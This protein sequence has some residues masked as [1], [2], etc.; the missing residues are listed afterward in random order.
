[1]YLDLFCHVFVL[2]VCPVFSMSFSFSPFPLLSFGLIFSPFHSFSLYWFGSYITYLYSFSGYSNNFSMQTWTY[3]S[4]INIFIISSKNIS[5]LEHSNTVTSYKVCAL[6]MYLSFLL[7]PQD[8]IITITILI[9][10]F[11]YLTIEVLLLFLFCKVCIFTYL[12]T[13]VIAP[14]FWLNLSSSTWIALPLPAVNNWPFSLVKVCWWQTQLCV[15]LKCL[16]FI[17]ILERLLLSIEFCFLSAYWQ[18]SCLLASF[19]VTEK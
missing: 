3:Q 15:C 5:N 8:D 2:S 6:I 13:P 18:Y 14:H 4:E 16:Y 10:K 1:M 19:L 7:T 12:F 11:K 17:L 9:K